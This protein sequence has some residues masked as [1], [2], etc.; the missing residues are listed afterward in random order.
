[1]LQSLKKLLLG[2]AVAAALI[3]AYD[4]PPTLAQ[5]QT[6]AVLDIHSFR[7]FG[8]PVSEVLGSAYTNATTS[9][10]AVTGLTTGAQQT[11]YDPSQLVSYNGAYQF[12][13]LW[14]NWSVN[15]RKATS[16]GGTCALA[17]NGNILAN[18]ATQFTPAA[19]PETGVINGFYDAFYSQDT[20]AF[21]VGTPGQTQTI[22]VQ[23]KSTDTATLTV[24]GGN[25]NVL[26]RF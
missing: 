17:L 16:T 12:D 20:S 24:L 5:A 8:A 25:L 10:T 23:C 2:S 13:H 18:S 22:T 15:I 3:A 4:L 11:V 7:A 14:I 26:E 19:W 9:Y 6:Q 21:N 1:M